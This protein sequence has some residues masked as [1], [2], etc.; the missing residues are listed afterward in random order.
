M[1]GREMLGGED[2]DKY[3]SASTLAPAAE[4][5]V[6]LRQ[7]TRTYVLLSHAARAGGVGRLD[8]AAPTLAPPSRSLLRERTRRRRNLFARAGKEQAALVGPRPWIC[9]HTGRVG[10]L[11]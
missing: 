1:A 9:G 5:T 4:A 8:H 7:P 10:G 6:L 2:K 3:G 11:G